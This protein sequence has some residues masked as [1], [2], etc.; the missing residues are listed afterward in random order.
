MTRRDYCAV[1]K[2]MVH[3]HEPK[4]DGCLIS[5][6]FSCATPYNS[7]V[8]AYLFSSKINTLPEPIVTISE[9]EQFYNDISGQEMMDEI[10]RC[11]RDSHDFNDPKSHGY[12]I[13]FYNNDME[14]VKTLL[15]TLKKKYNKKNA[16]ITDKD[17]IEKMQN[18]VDNLALY[19]CE[20]V[21]F[22]CY[23]CHKEPMRIL[24]LKY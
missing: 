24:D 17:D 3:D 20:A 8:R 16:K 1:C 2:Q 9:L 19:C 5:L 22:I 13:D 10:I 21:P 23:M 7:V 15:N 4:C 14:E 12:N 18:I 11:E 6:C